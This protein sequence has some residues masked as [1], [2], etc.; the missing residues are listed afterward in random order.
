MSRN[1][2]I[3][4]RRPLL[5]ERGDLLEPGW[6]RHLLSEYRREDIKASAFYRFKS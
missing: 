6:A 1:H 4:V 5:D 2:E 3:T